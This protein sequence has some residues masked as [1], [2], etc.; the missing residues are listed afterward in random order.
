MSHAQARSPEAAA[1]LSHSGTVEVSDDI[2]SSKWMKLVANA[3]ELVPSAILGLPL[4]EAAAVPGMREFMTEAGREAVRTAVATG[5]RVRPIFG[6]AD[7][8][9]ANPDRYAE[10][11]FDAVLGHFTLP[12]PRPRCCRTGSKDGEARSTRS[13]ALSSMSRHDWAEVLRRTSE[14]SNSP[15]GSRAGNWPRMSPTPRSWS[16]ASSPSRRCRGASA[17]RVACAG[18]GRRARARPPRS[19]SVGARRPG[20]GARSAPRGFHP[21]RPAG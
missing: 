2:R 9:L 16:P 6:M 19:R 18:C 11:L 20:A 4:S 21:D 15:T 8:D 10:Q 3:A 13:T 1:L 7:A 12:K 17:A 5:N 14:R